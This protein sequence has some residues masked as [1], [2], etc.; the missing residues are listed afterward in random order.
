[1]DFLI[2]CRGIRFKVNHRII[3]Q[4]LQRECKTQ[5]MVIYLQSGGFASPFLLKKHS[6][7]NKVVVAIKK[8]SQPFFEVLFVSRLKPS[9]I[10]NLKQCTVVR[11]QAVSVCE[12]LFSY[13]CHVTASLWQLRGE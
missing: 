10:V 8:A 4:R 12:L 11:L 9:D 5:I 6:S 13:L 7:A 1:M 3:S 2:Y